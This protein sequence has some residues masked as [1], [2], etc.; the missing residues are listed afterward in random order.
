MDGMVQGEP[1]KAL[2]TQAAV[3][4]QGAPTTNGQSIPSSRRD[5]P[6]S[7]AE[8]QKPKPICNS[9]KELEHVRA[10]GWLHTT[11]TEMQGMATDG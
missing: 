9:L 10:Q 5:R 6:P 1:L 8:S 7:A 2:S 3:A 4:G 11:A